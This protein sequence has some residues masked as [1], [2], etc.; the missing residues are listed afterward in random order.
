MLIGLH[1]AIKEFRQC[2]WYYFYAIWYLTPICLHGLNLM[3]FGISI[4]VLF[5]PIS[6]YKCYDQGLNWFSRN[7]NDIKLCT[8]NVILTIILFITTHN[9]HWESWIQNLTWKKKFIFE[10]CEL[11]SLVCDVL[12]GYPNCDW[13]H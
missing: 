8:K 2:T 7:L 11:Q 4:L 5:I 13:S 3:Q 6:C 1:D 9:T 12:L 10:F